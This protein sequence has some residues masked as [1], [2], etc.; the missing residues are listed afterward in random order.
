MPVT[1][2][3]PKPQGEAVNR[4][5]PTHEWTEVEAIPFEG[6]PPLPATRPNG[7][8]WPVWTKKRWEVWRSMPHCCL[9]D[10]ADWLFALDSLEIAAKFHENTGLIGMAAE[11]RNRERVLGTTLDFRR[12]LRIRYIDPKTV[13]PVIEMVK[14][15]FR[16]L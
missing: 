16:D 4:V 8:P 3:K 9:W 13:A 15:D 14:D 12:D 2:R 10:Q 11:L 5:A 7:K 1:G 6:G